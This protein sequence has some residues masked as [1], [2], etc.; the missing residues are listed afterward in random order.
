MTLTI[1]DPAILAA[2]AGGGES[3][4]I[5]GPGGQPLGHFVPSFEA[6]LAFFGLTKEEYE[7]RTNTP[8]SEW[9]SGAEVN[10]RL[11]SS[12]KLA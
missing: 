9:I 11:Q 5:V 6:T 3:V 10:A 8:K 2:L 12:R 7:R 4:E 1:T